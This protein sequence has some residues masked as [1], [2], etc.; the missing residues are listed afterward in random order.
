MKPPKPKR[1]LHGPWAELF[2]AGFVQHVCA[3]VRDEAHAVAKG[4]SSGLHVPLRERLVKPVWAYVQAHWEPKT[5]RADVLAAYELI[6]VAERL[7]ERFEAGRGFDASTFGAAARQLRL[8]WLWFI[9]H[10]AGPCVYWDA[11][12]AAA[13]RTAARKGKRRGWPLYI[14]EADVIEIER[15]HG[16]PR[17]Y[18]HVIWALCDRAKERAKAAGHAPRG[19]PIAAAT[20]AYDAAVKSGAIRPARLHNG[21]LQVESD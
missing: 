7:A 2:D 5:A 20:R 14:S 11:P 13:Q 8:A 1:A 19:K 18:D 10:V 3:L 12:R 9:A 16:G 15:L 6:D 17:M 21:D 4:G